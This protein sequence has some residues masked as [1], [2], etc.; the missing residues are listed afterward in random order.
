MT[1]APTMQPTSND[2]SIS[3][4][5]ENSCA[6]PERAVGDADHGESEGHGASGKE[7]GQPA[8]R[9]G[10]RYAQSQSAVSLLDFVVPANANKKLAATR[11]HS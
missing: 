8:C 10:E 7:D 1:M 3:G 5:E 2:K 9:R 4:R 11:G 6:L